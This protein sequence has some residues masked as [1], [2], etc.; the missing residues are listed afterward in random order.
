ML[1][2][3][4]EYFDMEYVCVCSIFNDFLKDYKAC[5]NLLTF[6]LL[7]TD[8]CLFPVCVIK[9]MVILC[10]CVYMFQWASVSA[11][12]LTGFPAVLCSY[13]VFVV[14]VREC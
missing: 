5:E 8:P 13:Y 10:L 11:V 7:C 2:L 1:S 6:C 12:I 9:F 4:M 14:Y 3:W